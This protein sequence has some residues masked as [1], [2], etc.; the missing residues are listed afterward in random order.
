M[1]YIQMIAC[2]H[3]PNEVPRTK[4][5]RSFSPFCMRPDKKLFRHEFHIGC[6]Y[7]LLLCFHD[8]GMKISSKHNFLKSE[9]IET[10]SPLL[11][12]SKSTL[13]KSYEKMH[14]AFG[15]FD[16]ESLVNRSPYSHIPMAA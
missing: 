11:S 12:F 2:L 9:R 7:E 4:N 3:M 14:D 16:V 5:K 1:P 10:K 13:V 8:A 15:K 6:W